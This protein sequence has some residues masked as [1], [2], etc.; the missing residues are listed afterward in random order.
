ML[1]LLLCAQPAWTAENAHGNRPFEVRDAVGMAYF[2]T[3]ESSQRD[4]LSDDGLISPDGR[5]ITKITHR[6]RLPEGVTEGTIWLFGTDEVRAFIRNGGPPPEPIPLVRMS[7]AVNGLTADWFNR[8]NTISE[9]AWADDARSLTFLGRDGRENRQLFRVDIATRA[10]TAISPDD[11]DVP[12][13][14]AAGRSLA[15]LALKGVN[16][17]ELWQSAGPNVP[18]IEVGVGKPLIAM[19][20]PNFRGNDLSGRLEAHLWRARDDKAQ[21]VVDDATRQ[22][23]S[24][25]VA[26]GNLTAS[27]SA[28][29][30]RLATTAYPSPQAAAPAYAIVDLDSGRLQAVAGASVRPY[31]YRRSA[32]FRAAWS[33]NDTQIAITEI[34]LVAAGGK[35]DP[36]T[37]G[38]A[39]LRTGTVRCVLTAERNSPELVRE[40]RWVSHD[41]L[42][43]ALK[44][45]GKE[46]HRSLIIDRDRQRW[47]APREADR[48][49]LP[50][51][52]FVVQ[53]SLN[54]RP[55]LV[56]VD[57]LAEKRR[58]IFDPNPQLD[59]V[60][61]GEVRIHEWRDRH[62]RTHRGGLVLPPHWQSDRRYPLVVQTH[63]FDPE[64]FFRVGDADTASA[65]RALAARDIIVLQVREPS[66][67]DAESW[68]DATELGMDV[69]LAGIDQLVRNG[70]VDPTKVGI[71]GYS[72]TGWTTAASIANAPDR[73]A[74]AV[75]ANTDPVTFTGYFAGVDSFIPRAYQDVYVG[76][77]PYG[78][79]LRLWGERVPLLASGRIEA[80]VLFS[81]AD[82]WHLISCWDLYAAMRDQNKPVELQYLRSGQHVLSKPLHKLAHQEMIVDWF[83]FWLAG[84][85]QPAPGKADQYRRWR[86]IRDERNVA[87]QVP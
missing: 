53:E 58:P 50:P 63:G 4:H 19:L 28:D 59:E 81:A 84:K 5:Y 39:D 45:F 37:I 46:L 13:Y 9:L 68:R 62:G 65:G 61:L 56:A 67:A 52:R 86:Q 60:E 51:I 10:R 69:Y 77:A 16:E 76:A 25:R 75:I 2:G 40:V 6:G 47:L 73:F 72:Y 20:Y 36:C 78:A 43:V 17:E 70:F 55:V 87:T 49:F 29:G 18:D 80:A 33:A 15:F 54:E 7:A 44:T 41:R 1:L 74:A 42:Y 11:V 66:A 24:L 31:R 30:A 34:D 27:L 79:G 64:R 32:L 26:Y 48:K 82:P 3:I 14:A 38:V 57:T 12:V 71:S 35:P 83:E 21:P 8:D 23:V 85:E 22:P